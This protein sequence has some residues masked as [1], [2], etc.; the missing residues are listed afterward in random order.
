MAHDGPKVGLA[1]VWAESHASCVLGLNSGSGELGPNC[2]PN[3]LGPRVENL[4]SILALFRC[5]AGP[6]LNI[7]VS[8]R[9]EPDTVACWA[10]PSH[11][12]TLH[13]GT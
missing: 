11:L 9:A 8:T 13:G 10:G 7:A 2:R 12:T 4:N 3:G 1:H 5:R 6:A